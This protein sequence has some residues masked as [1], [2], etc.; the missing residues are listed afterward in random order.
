M[1]FEQFQTP[2][3][4]F[5]SLQSLRRF[6]IVL[7]PTSNYYCLIHIDPYHGALSFTGVYGKDMFLTEKEAIDY[8][9]K[10]DPVKIQKRRRR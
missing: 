10:N 9:S 8:L 2:S 4:T 1:T 5:I 7:T 6:L 3:V